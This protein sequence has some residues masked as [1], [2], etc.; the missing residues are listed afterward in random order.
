MP[1]KILKTSI[2][3]CFR[4]VKRQHAIL[5]LADTLYYGKFKRYCKVHIAQ[6]RPCM[7]N[8]MKRP[9]YLFA[10]KFY[11]EALDNL[12]NIFSNFTII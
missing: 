5:I 6:R 1:Y 11:P 10:R 12:M 3:S 7:W 9:C 2:L 8:G 4:R